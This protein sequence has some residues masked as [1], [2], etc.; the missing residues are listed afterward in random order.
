MRIKRKN[1]FRYTLNL[2]N[3]TSYLRVYLKKKVPEIGKKCLKI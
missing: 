3:D 2:I 1:L